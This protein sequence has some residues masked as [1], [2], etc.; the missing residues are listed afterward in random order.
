MGF[1]SPPHLSLV[2]NPDLK[3]SHWQFPIIRGKVLELEKRQFIR[4]KVPVLR[5][6]SRLFLVLKKGGEWRLIIDLSIHSEFLVPKHFK[7]ES[8]SKIALTILEKI[9]GN[10][11]DVLDAYWNLPI[12]WW[13]QF[14]LAFSLEIEPR[15]RKIYVF[16]VLPFGLASAP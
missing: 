10:T 7:R 15:I 5:F 8:I 1:L 16:T 9:W 14:F 4:S 2:P 12:N 11:L 6:I 13:S 3:P